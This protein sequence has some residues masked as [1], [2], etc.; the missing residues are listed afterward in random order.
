TFLRGTD[1]L[2]LSCL[3]RRDGGRLVACR[4]RVLDLANEAAGARQPRLIDLGAARDLARGFSGGSGV[5]H[6]YPLRR[7]VAA[8]R[9]SRV[10]KNKGRRGS[11]RRL[12]MLIVRP[13]LRVNGRK[14]SP[15]PPGGR[16]LRRSR[17]PPGRGRPPRTGQAAA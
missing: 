11:R 14:P 1:D 7:A 2:W 3:E 15:R 12:R 10:A 16:A 6:R 8:P 9:V 17:R 4:D 13:F 5:G